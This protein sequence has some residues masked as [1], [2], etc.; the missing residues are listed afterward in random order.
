VQLPHIGQERTK[1]PKP[2]YKTIFESSTNFIIKENVDENVIKKSQKLLTSGK[3]TSVKKSAMQ[4]YEPSF[5][6]ITDIKRNKSIEESVKK[7]LE[8]PT[9]TRN[10]TN[11]YKIGSL[12][13]SLTKCTTRNFKDANT[14][15]SR[16]YKFKNGIEY[17]T[18]HT[19]KF[20]KQLLFNNDL[21]KAK[22]VIMGEHSSENMQQSMM[23]IIQDYLDQKVSL[24][25]ILGDKSKDL[26]GEEVIK[27][28]NAYLKEHLKELDETSIAYFYNSNEP[29]SKIIIRN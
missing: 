26:K 13:Q 27:D 5:I 29:S 20:I 19:Q 15:K 25:D 24:E 18:E 9:R 14:I 11:D 2:F 8:S 3:Q 17:S 10:C 16:V 6:T 21:L 7:S 28:F 12:P 1:N 23:D 22:T 4:A